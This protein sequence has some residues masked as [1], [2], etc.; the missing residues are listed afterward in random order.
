[1][2][3]LAHLRSHIVDDD[4]FL[5]D[6]IQTYLDESAL[7]LTR[8]EAALAAGDLALIRREAHAL[9]GS[10]ASLYL[11]TASS[12]FGRLESESTD[13]PERMAALLGTAV[14]AHREVS[15]EL[16]MLRRTL[17]AGS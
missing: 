6:L 12:A 16:R 4:V 14:A 1:M 10:A 11:D 7:R 15:E 13:D 3:D 9:R 17:I 5:A 8:A 2:V